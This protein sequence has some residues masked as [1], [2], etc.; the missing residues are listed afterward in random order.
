M[1]EFTPGPWTVNWGPLD[2]EGQAVI[3]GPGAEPI[4][5][6]ADWNPDAHSGM[7]DLA[8]APLLAAAPDLYAACEAAEQCITDLIACIRRGA[9]DIVVSEALGSCKND[10][11]PKIKSALKKAT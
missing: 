3:L 9:A 7:P 5:F 6:V 11:L 10:A 1:S 8:N 4:A 2:A